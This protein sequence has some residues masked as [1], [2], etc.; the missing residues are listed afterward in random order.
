MDTDQNGEYAYFG[1]DE[2]VN[3]SVVKSQGEFTTTLLAGTYHFQPLGWFYQKT[4]LESTTRW[5]LVIDWDSTGIDLYY[6]TGNGDTPTSINLNN[7]A[8]SVGTSYNITLSNLGTQTFVEIQDISSYPT[9]PII[10]S[11]YT[12]TE[13]YDATSLYAGFGQWCSGAGNIYG[14]YDDFVIIDSEFTY[15]ADGTGF[16]KV[17]A[18]LDEV[19]T[20]TLYDLDEGSDPILEIYESTTNIT[21]VVDCWLNSTTYFVSTIAEGKAIIRHNITVTSTNNTVVFSQNNLTYVS[22]VDYGDNVF[23]YQYSVELDFAPIY[24]NIYTVV[25]TYEVYW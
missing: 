5:A 25:L 3:H 18:Y 21:L 17:D 16:N 6:N 2:F 14:W 11:G 4:N 8:P 13:N 12:T 1:F 24:G 23:L 20:Q 15:S 10:Y 9:Y 7:T 19:F 22:G